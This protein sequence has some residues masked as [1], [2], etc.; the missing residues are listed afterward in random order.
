MR[1][2]LLTAV[3]LLALLS[4]NALAK[5]NLIFILADDLGSG[6][7]GCFGQKLIQ[8]PH[9]DQMAREGLRFTA[10]Y[11]GASVCAPSRASLMIGQHTGHSPIRANREIKPE[12]QFPLPEGTLTVAHVLKSAGYTTGAFGKW[13]MG[14]PGSSGT[15]DKMG[16]DH[17]FGYN[18]QRKAH[19]YYPTSLWRNDQTVELDGKTWS[20]DVIVAEALRWIGSNKDKPFFAFMPLTNPHG[21]WQVPA[22]DQY[23]NKDWPEVCKNY[24]AMV[25]RLDASV[26]HLFAL[27]KELNIDDNTAV[28]FASDNGADNAQFLKLFISNQGLRGSKRSPYEGGIRSPSI[29]RWPGRIKPGTTSDTPWAF[30]DFLP[31]AAEIAGATIPSTA[32]LDGV[33]IVPVLEGKTLPERTLYW[34]L[35]EGKFIQNLRQGNWTL[36]KPGPNAPVELY[37]LA[38]DPQQ[39]TN[40]AAENPQVVQRLAP[41]LTSMRFPDPNWPDT[42]G[43]QPQK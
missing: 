28:F 17:F 19:E 41:L 11:S 42:A 24:A 20:H 34:E 39:Q 26:G 8:T 31:T 4:P 18:C 43:R 22:Q 38:K 30:Y 35:H 25:S 23:A 12:G 33:S 36:C 37:D 1:N 13:G 27:L 2:L 21:K 32:R 10:A 15:P 7:L 3:A 6:D 16:F 40:I 9:L 14:H 29:A 5:P